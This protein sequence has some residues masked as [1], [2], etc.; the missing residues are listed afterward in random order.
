MLPLAGSSRVLPL[1]SALVRFG[2]LHTFNLILS[3]AHSGSYLRPDA[4]LRRDLVTYSRVFLRH[5]VMPIL[6]TTT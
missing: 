4:H 1:M 6:V 2:L 5:K 3:L